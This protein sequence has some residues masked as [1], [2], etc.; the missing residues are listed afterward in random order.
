MRIDS[1]FLDVALQK[2]DEKRRSIG[3]A[4]SQE[5]LKAFRA[6]L[7]EM[8]KNRNYGAD[9]DLYHS[10]V[11]TVK[12]HWSD[13]MLDTAR[14][15]INKDAAFKGNTNVGSYVTEA[16][17]YLLAL[18]QKGVNGAEFSVDTVQEMRKMA[19]SALTFINSKDKRGICEITAYEAFT[20]QR[21]KDA[22][23]VRRDAAELM[24][25]VGSGKGTS[26]QLGNLYAEWRALTE[27]QAGHNFVWKLFHLLENS[28]R[29]TLLKDM[30]E[31]LR[32]MT[33]GRV[34]PTDL[35]PSQ[36]AMEREINLAGE[37]ITETF[38]D[39]LSDT[40]AAFGYGEYVNNPELLE[41]FENSRMSMK[42]DIDLIS[43]VKDDFLDNNSSMDLDDDDIIIIKDDKNLYI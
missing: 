38:D 6:A 29:N 14:A 23:E 34:P 3:V 36:I 8:T 31:S 26:A 5:R 21:G 24:T 43:D 15:F 1:K 42:D 11:E 37:T 28:R 32:A 10:D 12:Q 30:K 39:I 4:F 9:K 7:D 33:G 2:A 41:K 17:R 20:R 40:G 16:A 19:H 35:E 25:A 18:T 22:K 13:L 27:R